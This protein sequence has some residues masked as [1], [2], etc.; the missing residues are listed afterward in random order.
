[1]A[2]ALTQ[3][4]IN[5]HHQVTVISG[6]VNVDYPVQAHV[7]PVMTTQQ[8]LDACLDHVSGCD[9]VIAVAAPCDFRPQTYAEQKIKKVD[10]QPLTLH[11][12]P[13]P[14]IL[15]AL[16]R[17]NPDA[18]SIGF[19]LE[20]QNGL[21]HAVEKKHRKGCDW[22]LL[23]QASAIGSAD[24]RI[25]IIDHRDQPREPVWGSKA[26]VAEEIVR[27]LQAHFMQATVD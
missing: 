11:L 9:G 16:Q 24:T 19:A 14:D 25:Q 8:M 17:A 26:N 10:D 13:T 18:W 22:I 27:Q 6:P 12:Q 21:Q 2:C 7:V 23:N 3:A 1:M 4:L 20:T 5:R 15:A